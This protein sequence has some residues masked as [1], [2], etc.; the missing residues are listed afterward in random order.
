MVLN[1][2]RKTMKRELTK[3]EK[4]RAEAL[5][6]FDPGAVQAILMTGFI[7][8][9][10]LAMR[11]CRNRAEDLRLMD[12]DPLEADTCAGLIRICQVEIGAGRMKRPDFTKE[13]MDEMDRIA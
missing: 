1:K 9:M 12:K 2:K 13:E 6:D 7:A 11:L 5:V 4:R 3:E 10:E 8:G